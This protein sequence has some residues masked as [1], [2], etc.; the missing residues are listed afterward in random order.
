ML[1]PSEGDTTPSPSHHASL[2]VSWS[3]LLV[4]MSAAPSIFTLPPTNPN[5]QTRHDLLHDTPRPLNPKPTPAPSRFASPNRFELL[6]V[7]DLPPPAPVESPKPS[8]HSPQ[9]LSISSFP[10]IA[11]TGCT[12]LLL[13]FSNFPALSPFFTPKPL[14]LVPFTLPDRSVLLVGGPSHLTG[15][16]T[17]PHKASPVSAY[18]LPDSNLSHSLLGISPL[19]RPNGLAI[20]TPTS[21]KIFDTPTSTTPFLSGTKSPQSDLWFFTAP[22]P[23]I[24]PVPSTA[25]FSLSSLPLARFV[26]Y[27]H[28]SFGSPPISTFLRALSRGYIH[29]IPKL[30][31]T[32]VRKFP[33]LSLATSYGHLDTL[34]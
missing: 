20:F 4:T 3:F 12:G 18:F 8:P 13:Q 22:H 29:G 17:F 7:P 25:L 31:A 24:P 14:P 19:I 34:R 15:E 33:P 27:M 11:D 10:L 32:L 16:L 2:S 23:P 5:K 9:V 1:M 21:V 6:S 30:T 26:A 28:R